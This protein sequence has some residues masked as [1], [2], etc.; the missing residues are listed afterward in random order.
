MQSLSR[1]ESKIFLVWMQ[2][3]SRMPLQSLHGTGHNFLGHC[4]TS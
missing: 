3:A 2:T 4:N 1:Q